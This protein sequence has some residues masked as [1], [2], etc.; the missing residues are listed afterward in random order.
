MSSSGTQALLLAE[1][2]VTRTEKLSLSAQAAL[3]KQLGPFGFLPKLL[4]LTYTVTFFF[5]SSS[6]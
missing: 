3:A 2:S 6:F 1:M 5:L 4:N